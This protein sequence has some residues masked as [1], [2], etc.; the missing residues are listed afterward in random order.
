MKLD[1]ISST[2]NKTRRSVIAVLVVSLLTVTALIGER[3]LYSLQLQSLNAL[4]HEATVQNDKVVL[5]DEILTMSGRMFAATGIAEW[6][7]RY[8]ANVPVMDAAIAAVLALAPPSI[9][10]R[11][12]NET[13]AANDK[14]IAMEAQAFELG[15]AKNLVGAAA[16]L[17]SAEYKTN[18][19]L[20]TSG[21][22]RF[23][24]AL[25]SYI[26]VKYQAIEQQSWVIRGAGASALLLIGGVWWR[27]N[28]NLSA[29]ERDYRSAEKARLE[30]EAAQTAAETSA[31]DIRHAERQRQAALESA[32]SVFRSTI[33]ETQFAVSAHVK[34]LND[35]SVELLD[36][37]RSAGSSMQETAIATGESIESA[38]SVASASEELRASIGDIAQQIE[39]IRLASSLTSELA[40]KS[41]NQI[42]TFANATHQIEQIVGL[43]GAVADQTNLLAL[44]AT[45]EAARAGDAGRGFAVVA[46]EVKALANQTAKATND[47]S[48]QIDEIRSSTEATVETMR[49]VVN[50]ATE[51]DHAIGSIATV[52]QQQSVTTDEVS[53][54]ALAGAGNV[55]KLHDLIAEISTT[56]L[57]ANQA[58]QAVASVSK[59]LNNSSMQIGDSI[60]AFLKTAE[61][62]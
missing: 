58:A 30:S 25:D 22:D 56:L 42:N 55:D 31:H 27:L 19:D 15:A 46:N 43:I 21:S 29:F 60:G 33:N 13:S 3:Y 17:E 34:Q 45:I 49:Q 44:N 37:S 35:T 36:I 1:S 48:Q 20:L 18:K 54:S 53:R 62:A 11:F 59:D 61:A 10:E 51:M 6:K 57:K 14:L 52:I 23:V 8:D 38:R 24:A 9:A 47:I 39:S 41:N 7:V 2:V 50:N 28:R 26:V 4:R 12:K 40:S 5:A 32:I 16:V